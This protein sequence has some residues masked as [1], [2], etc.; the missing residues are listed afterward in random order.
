M[1][2]F[3]GEPSNTSGLHEAATFQVD[4]HVRTCTELLEDIELLAK[5]SKG[6]MVALDAKYHTKCLVKLYNHARKVKAEKIQSTSDREIMSNF[7]FAELVIYIKEMRLSE[8]E[9][10]IFKLSE[11]AKLYVSRM[12]QLGISLDKRIHTT[13]LKDRLW[14]RGHWYSIKQSM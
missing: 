4:K 5:L 1:C 10:P 2:F 12:E 8:D 14:A 6:D 7:V 13:R 3:C 11:L 9:A